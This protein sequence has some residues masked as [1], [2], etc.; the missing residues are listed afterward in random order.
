MHL[1]PIVAILFLVATVPALN[2]V[3]NVSSH[4]D[5]CALIDPERPPQSVVYDTKLDSEIR[6]RL[7]NNST[8]AIV[9]ETDDSYPTELKRL[10]NGGAR[11]EAV[12]VPRDGLRVRLHYL[13]QRR[14]KAELLKGGLG[15][16]DSVFTYEIPPGQSITFDVPMTHFKNHYDIAVPFNYAWEGSQSVSA[17][18][19][20]V[21]HRVYFLFEDATSQR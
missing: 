13:I 20:G 11:I 6:L 8:C 17:G 14:N 9:V 3:Q 18:V 19:G 4:K 15:W 1:S 7:R 16:G 10:P 2:M 5:A 21:V 12:L